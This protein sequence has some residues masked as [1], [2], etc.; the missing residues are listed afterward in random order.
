MGVEPTLSAWKAEVIAD[1][2]HP[3][4]VIGRCAASHGHNPRVSSSLLT[5]ASLCNKVERQTRLELATTRLEIWDS[6]IELLPHIKDLL[7]GTFNPS[8]SV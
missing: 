5:N 7:S 8:T 6:T 2:P 3:H 1:I 4:I